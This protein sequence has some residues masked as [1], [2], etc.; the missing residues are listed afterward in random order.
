V[1]FPD[2]SGVTMGSQTIKNPWIRRDVLFDT[3]AAGWSVIGS[4]NRPTLA[5]APQAS[6]TSVLEGKRTT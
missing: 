6:K 2:T 3:A 1:G 5:D 4:V